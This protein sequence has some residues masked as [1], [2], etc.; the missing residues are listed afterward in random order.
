M[1][2]I[3]HSVNCTL[4]TRLPAC[5]ALL[6]HA[7]DNVQSRQRAQ[8]QAARGHI[9]C[10]FGVVPLM[11]AAAHA[12]AD[13]WQFYLE[14]SLY[15]REVPTAGGARG[16]G[17]AYYV[18]MLSGLQLFRSMANQDEADAA[19]VQGSD[20]FQVRGSG[21]TVSAWQGVAKELPPWRRPGVV[22]M[23]ELWRHWMQVAV[24]MSMV[25]RAAVYAA[26]ADR[27]RWGCAGC[28]P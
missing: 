6:L 25:S 13:L 3:N 19:A 20:F 16:P 17:R 28:I 10:D 5:A 4:V 1:R 2:L 21:A 27:S 22:C 12:Q 8:G 7:T 26:R 15:G 23:S 11:K 18:P 14:P 9:A 24:F